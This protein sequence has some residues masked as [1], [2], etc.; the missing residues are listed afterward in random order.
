MA[1]Y[2]DD[3]TLNTALTKLNYPFNTIK[4]VFVDMTDLIKL[5]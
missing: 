5:L 1:D 4:S 2:S 3:K